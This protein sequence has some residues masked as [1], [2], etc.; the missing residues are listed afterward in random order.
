MGKEV[1]ITDEEKEK[2]QKV[3]DA[4]EELYKQTDIIVIN[5]G[6]YGFVKLQYYKPLV[7]FDSVITYTD[8]Q[9]MFNDLWDDWLY[10]QLL[11]PV[12]ETSI[13]EFEYE[14]IFKCLPKERQEELMAKREYFRERSEGSFDREN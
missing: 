11:T 1:Y 14:D 9:T 2:C 7:G 4:F 5:A 10:D 6:K 12:L 3:A 8:S 13:A